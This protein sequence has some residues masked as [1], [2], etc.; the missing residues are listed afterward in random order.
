MRTLCIAAALALAGCP[1]IDLDPCG[2]DQDDP[3]PPEAWASL[4]TSSAFADAAVGRPLSIYAQYIVDYGESCS[5]DLGGSCTCTD[6]DPSPSAFDVV[7]IGCDDDACDVEH[8][9]AYVSPLREIVVVPKR[10][11]VTVRIRL[12]SAGGVEPDA[13]GELTLVMPDGG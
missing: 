13:T 7:E 11:T 12:G 1:S 5:G 9:S 3:A 6:G 8:V 4:T 10:G 2:S